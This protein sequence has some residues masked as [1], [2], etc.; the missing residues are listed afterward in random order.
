MYEGLGGGV[1]GI[2]DWVR[3]GAPFLYLA[4]GRRDFALRQCS[5]LVPSD[6]ISKFL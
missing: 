4:G 6:V 5:W 3:K 1:G 2:G